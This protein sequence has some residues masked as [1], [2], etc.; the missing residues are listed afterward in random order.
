[1]ATS[2]N[3]DRRGFLKGAA[4]LAGTAPIALA[5]QTQLAQ[6]RATAAPAEVSGSPIEVLTNERPG[7]DFMLDVIKSLGIEYTAANPASSCRG[8]HESTINYGS[9]KNPELLTA[10]HEESSVAMCHGYAKIEGKPMMSMVHGTVGTQHGAM[11]IYNAYCDRVPAIVILGN[12]MDAVARRSYVEWTHSAQDAAS[13]IRD[14]T[15]WDDAPT[16]LQH[17]A[18]S[19]VRAY[20]IAM[21]PPMG[22]VAIIASGKLQ[23]EPIE[24]KDLRIPKLTPML[25]PSG[26]SGAVAEAA[27]MLVAAEN[28][29]IVAGRL[30]RT[31]NGMKLLAELADTLQ[32]PV[33][34]QRN[35]M[36]IAS[37]HPFYN[38]GSVANADLILALEVEDIFMLTHR[39]SPLNRI[40]MEAP[41][42][43]IKDTAK[44]ISVS[45]V[46]LFQRSNYQDFAR[47]NEVDMAIPGD[48]EATLPA[49]IEACKK[50]ITSDRRM[51]MQAR[52]A[53]LAE[54]HKKNRETALAQAT[55]GWDSSPLAPA[56]ISAELWAQI[57]NED[58]SLVGNDV[59]FNRWPTRLWNFDKYYQF[60]GG[61]GGEGVG[62]GAPA[63]VGAALANKKHGRLTINIQ[64][65]GDLNYAP[66]VLWTAV[67]HNIPM[68]T[69]MNNNRGYHQEV[70]FV[71]TMAARANRDVSRAGIGTKLESPFIDYA[72]MAKAYGM[73]GIGPI[74]DPKDV[75]PAI[76]RALE[77]VKRGE[78]VLI[79]TV[80]QGRG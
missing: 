11:A 48:G 57:K 40:G 74:T 67:H 31:P 2:K 68:L 34:D 69:V 24:E 72:S 45:S 23:E 71:T 33:N 79:D 19:F 30:A 15:K 76:K 54:Q 47:Y 59:F 53:R 80:T 7:A 22:P 36:N 50:L 14:Y 17:F 64:N 56:R 32:A 4:A 51:A 29:V 8:L 75:G 26:D 13:I 61:S 58:W 70:M 62:Y 52:G 55:L 35:R 28:P 20:K 41:R 66:G 6:N 12:E 18:E 1:M 25:A 43:I 16:S 60:I 27:K 49:L 65:D 37:S 44:I 42:K 9:N 78:P 38:T 3:T 46:D 39:M 21:T 73:M 5:Q 77:V 10:C 63:A